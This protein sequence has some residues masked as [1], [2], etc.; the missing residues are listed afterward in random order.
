MVIAEQGEPGDI[1]YIIVSGE[2]VVSTV[3]EAGQM[4]ELGRRQSG[5]YVGEMAIISD[6]VRMATLTAAGAVRT[7]C[8]NQRQFKEILRLRPEVALAVMAGLSQR[9]R[10]GH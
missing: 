4:V 2:V 9:L 1:L 6:E 7:L 8:I 10:E 5:E 3:D